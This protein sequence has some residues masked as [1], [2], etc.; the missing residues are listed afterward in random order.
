MNYIVIDLEWNQAANK[1][2]SEAKMPFEIIEIGAVKLNEEFRMVSQ[3]NRLIKPKVYKKI[4]YKIEEVTHLSINDLNKNGQDFRKVIREFFKWCGE[5]Y[6]FC[7]WGT[8]D[9]TELERNI[10]FFGIEIPFPKPLLYY[11]LQRMYSILYRD[12]DE[13]VALD[14]AVD[15]LKLSRRRPF[16]RAK[17]DA[18]Y[19]A[20]VMIAM[21]FEKVRDCYSVDYYRPPSN[22]KEEFSVQS[23]DG[24]E[25]VS[26]T[27]PTKEEIMA[28]KVVTAMECYQCHKKLRK[29]I[30]WFTLNSKQYYALA[31]C[32]Q[33]GYMVGKIRMKKTDDDKNFVIK[34]LQ[35][36]EEDGVEEVRQ[37]QKEMH[38][39]RRQKFR[40]QMKKLES[41]EEN[42]RIQVVEDGLMILDIEGQP[43][44]FVD[45]K[46]YRRRI[47]NLRKRKEN[48]EVDTW[49]VVSRR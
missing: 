17:D 39:K 10:R 4:H 44:P 31:Q 23:C 26:M 13:K 14:N 5:E 6:T 21:D 34:T 20:R 46:L 38:K 24:V 43:K 40:K 35:F 28:D 22:R 15:E 36:V 29:K 41:L 47:M 27:Y 3:F 48:P 42:G 33:H 9:L 32:P 25:F 49:N 19:T 45:S 8:M 18:Y 37:K 16:H 12:G 2:Q 30:H 1:E 11:D 7:T